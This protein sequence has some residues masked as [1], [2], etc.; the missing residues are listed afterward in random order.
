M[1]DRPCDCLHPKVHCAVVSTASG[2]VQGEMQSYTP[3][4]N[5]AT[6]SAIWQMHM[7]YWLHHTISF[8][9]DGSL[10]MNICQ[11]RGIADQP[12][13]VS[14]NQSDWRFVWYHNIRSPS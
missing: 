4:K 13:L 2:S 1:A 10:S 12:V 7:K 9:W 14:E 5:N 8:A 11:G 3:S 6:Q